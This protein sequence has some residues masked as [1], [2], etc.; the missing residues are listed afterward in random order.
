MCVFRWD[1]SQP[2]QKV[3]AACFSP[4]ADWGRDMCPVWVTVILPR[5]VLRSTY[6]DDPGTTFLSENLVLTISLPLNLLKSMGNDR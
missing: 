5:H 6:F 3:F 4:A 2:E 1:T